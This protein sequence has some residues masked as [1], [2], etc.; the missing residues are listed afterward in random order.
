MTLGHDPCGGAL[1]WTEAALSPGVP[2]A[3]AAALEMLNLLKE[4]YWTEKEIPCGCIA[5]CAD[6]KVIF[7]NEIITLSFS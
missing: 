7:V 5:V 6:W 4:A 1:R 3:Q 2:G